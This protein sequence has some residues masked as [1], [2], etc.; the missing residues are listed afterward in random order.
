[1]KPILKELTLEL[2]QRCPNFCLHCSSLSSD[3]SSFLIDTQTA[4]KVCEEARDLGIKKICL[5]G[6][7]PL[8]HPN[9]YEIIDFIINRL[10][11]KVAL[12]TT[13]IYQKGDFVANVNWESLDRDKISLIFGFHSIRKEIHNAL[14]RKSFSY[15]FTMQSIKAGLA[16]GYNVEIHLVPN[17][18]NLISIEETVHA[19]HIMGIR[20]ISFL[21][22]V[23]Q[24][25]AK[26][27]LKLLRLDPDESKRL[28]FIYNSIQ[29]EYGELLRFGI[30]F[31]TITDKSKRCNAGESKLIIRYDGKILPCEAF[32]DSGLSVYTLGDIYSGSLKK[33]LFLTSYSKPLMELKT[34]VGIMNETCPAQLLYE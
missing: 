5:S 14:T 25:F 23:P 9:I 26:I 3:K 2:T 33:A 12:Y 13:G 6:G 30:P 15:A 32:K 27:N 29:K 31:S 1:M 24:G 21:R 11:L 10:N 4:K 34:S 22:L 28:H 8:L 17:K 18:V 16:A 20:R 19:L 7:E